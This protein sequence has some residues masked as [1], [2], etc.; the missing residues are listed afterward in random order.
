[1]SVRAILFAALVASNGA[2]AQRFAG[3]VRNAESGVPIAGAVVSALSTTDSVVAR[4]VTNSRGEFTI[5][6]A[7]VTIASLR[8]IHLGYLPAA[9]SP[10]AGQINFA[11]TPMAWSLGTIETMA[12]AECPLRDDAAV[13]G[14][15]WTQAQ[16]ARL[17][18]KVAREAQPARMRMI[19]YSRTIAFGRGMQ[20]PHQDTLASKDLIQVGARPFVA[21][22]SPTDFAELGYAVTTAEGFTLFG[23]DDETLLDSSFVRTHCFQITRSKDQ[24]G[25][26]GITFAPVRSRDSLV[27][28]TGTLWVDSATATLQSVGYG[29]TDLP[30]RPDYSERNPDPKPNRFA[31]GYMEFATAQNG[32]PFVTS[33]WL[34]E[35]VRPREGQVAKVNREGTGGRGLGIVL[36]LTP[37]IGAQLVDVQWQ[38]GTRWTASLPTVRGTVVEQRT[39]TARPGLALR[40]LNA[41]RV[42]VTDSLGQYDF[43]ALVPGPYLLAVEDSLSAVFWSMVG[44][45]RPQFEGAKESTAIGDWLKRVNGRMNDQPLV[46]AIQVDSNSHSDITIRLPDFDKSVRDKCGRAIRADS[47]GALAVWVIR[48]SAPVVEAS[49]TAHWDVDGRTIERSERTDERGR[50]LFCGAPKGHAVALTATSREAAPSLITTTMRNDHF[51]TFQVIPFP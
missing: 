6:A 41:D 23:P 31:G 39:G 48:E 49:V 9:A 34:R 35:P 40:L 18:G 30:I 37:E 45:D 3:T 11:M 24:P 28:I 2:A 7:V 36:E 12:R 4:T 20:A 16:G 51:V 43:G 10:M 15:L 13:A 46:A 21:A 8:A 25:R 17:A 50:A 33:W 42:V 38:D 22:R 14:L 32:I 27:E 26:V 1:M 29:Y 19:R 5:N 47:A 44:G